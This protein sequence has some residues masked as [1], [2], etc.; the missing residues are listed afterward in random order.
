MLANVKL[1]KVMSYDKV[2]HITKTFEGDTK[3]SSGEIFTYVLT[4]SNRYPPERIVVSPP[5]LF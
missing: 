5:F 4:N 2:L 3:I 1:Q